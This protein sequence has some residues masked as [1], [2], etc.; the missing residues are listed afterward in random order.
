[1]NVLSIDIGIT[2]MAFIFAHVDENYN[3]KEIISCKKVNICVCNHKKNCKLN[4]K[5]FHRLSGRIR[6]FIDSHEEF[7]KA[8]IIICEKQPPCGLLIVEELLL[9]NFP[10]MYLVSP[11]AMHAYYD[12]ND[13]EYEK[14]KEITV[15]ISKKKLNKF[16]SFRKN[17]RK[18]DMA[19]SYCLLKYWLSTT[20]KK[21]LEKR[22]L[23]EWRARN[24]DLIVQFETYKYNG[25]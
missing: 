8:D 25:D 4:H 22:Q 21:L 17:E 12:M 19:D 14:R 5:N 13:Y 3:L 20:G 9:F 6:H 2:N 11:N 16:E 10:D 15:S 18:H 23:D 24:R 1:M 7:K